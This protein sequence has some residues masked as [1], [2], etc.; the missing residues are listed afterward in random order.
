MNKITF[1]NKAWE[2]YCYWQKQ[3]KKTITRRYNKKWFYRNW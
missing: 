1:T 2:E 3:D